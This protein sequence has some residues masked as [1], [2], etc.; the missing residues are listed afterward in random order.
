MISSRL[1][2]VGVQ[3]TPEGE[4]AAAGLLE[5]SLGQAPSI[6][7]REGTDDTAVSVYLTQL[8]APLRAVRAAL[9]RGLEELRGSALDIGR[10][11]LVI[12]L[13]P[14]ENW[15]ESWKRHFRPIDI[16]RQ[17]LVKPGWSRRR[18]KPGQRIVILDPG[19]SFGTGQHPTTL[20]CLRHLARACR[21][22]TKQ[23]FLDLGCG[24]GILAIAAAKLGYC[25]VVALDNDPE[26]VRASR[27]NIWRNKVRVT[28]RRAE[29]TRLPLAP[30]QRFD[31][32]CANLTCDLLAKE[33]EKIR[34]LLKPGG[35]LAVAG[36]LRRE[37]AELQKNLHRIN[38][39]LRAS[40]VD[41][42]WKSGRFALEAA[43]PP[44]K[45]ER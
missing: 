4:E 13:L 29:L 17:L 21:P 23:S 32:V 33:A 37:F 30:S 8:P 42:E 5:R 6:Y 2:Q 24:S 12:K 20:F 34:N 35:T 45:W 16:G 1:W 26:A 18:A 9:E 3:T 11:R 31:V 39:T 27:A 25:P 43:L 38:L 19:L 7:R 10:A 40:K 44:G 28:V 36:V 22:G 15:A 14:K 41:K